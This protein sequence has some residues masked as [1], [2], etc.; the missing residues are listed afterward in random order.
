MTNLETITPN[1]HWGLSTEK[2]H[3]TCTGPFVSRG[4]SDNPLIQVIRPESHTSWKIGIRCGY[5]KT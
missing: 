3:N 2:V 5:M 4:F 1:W